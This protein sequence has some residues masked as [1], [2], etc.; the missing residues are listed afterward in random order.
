MTTSTSNKMTPKSAQFVIHD[1]VNSGVKEPRL[2]ISI[3][4]HG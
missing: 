3:T 2:D 4:I 1:T